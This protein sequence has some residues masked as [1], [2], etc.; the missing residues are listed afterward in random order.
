MKKLLFLLV[1]LI[2]IQMYSQEHFKF[3]G[4][5]I[6]GKADEFVGKLKNKGFKTI[7]HI[8]GIMEGEFAGQSVQLFIFSTKKTNTVWKVVA[9]LKKQNTWD[10][11]KSQYLKYKDLYSIKYGKSNDEAEFFSYPYYEGCGKELQ[12]LRNG[13]GVYRTVFKLESGVI[14]VGLSEFEAVSLEYEDIINSKLVKKEEDNAI[15]D[16]I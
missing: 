10:S 2:S 3:N 6:D 11:L 12:A 9:V 14:I 15:L 16:D 7:P 1:L 8:D 4:V 13:K 5:P